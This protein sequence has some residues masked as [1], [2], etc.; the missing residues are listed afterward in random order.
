MKVLEDNDVFSHNEGGFLK[1]G[2]GVREGEGGVLPESGFGN[3]DVSQSG[4]EVASGGDEP[5]R[6]ALLRERAFALDEAGG[7]ALV[8]ER[9]RRRRDFYALIN[10]PT[11]SVV[12][13]NR[14]SKNGKGLDL[15]VEPSSE[16]LTQS[17]EGLGQDFFRGIVVIG[18][19]TT[20]EEF[21]IV[22]QKDKTVGVKWNDCVKKLEANDNSLLKKAAAMQGGGQLIGVYPDGRLC[23]KDRGNEPVTYGYN[24]TKIFGD[25]QVD[26]A[27]KELLVP[28]SCLEILNIVKSAG[29]TLPFYFEDCQEVGIIPAIEAVTGAPYVG[30]GENEAW[31]SAVLSDFQNGSSLG[32]DRDSRLSD[33]SDLISGDSRR[34][35]SNGGTR[36]DVTSFVH[37]LDSQLNDGKNGISNVRAG[38]RN[39]RIGVV[40]LL[41][42]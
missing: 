40:R 41:I 12:L 42:G 39:G 32:D 18:F 37:V 4:L 1:S 17:F 5:D 2:S 13:Q 25:A 38:E 33:G 27:S 11:P 29:Y 28:L 3:S 14:R 21:R 35:R 30:K 22:L 26:F 10:S 16:L 23:I 36:L 31:R 20:R 24:C 34:S 8:I 19:N 9:E 6:E 7:A 15:S